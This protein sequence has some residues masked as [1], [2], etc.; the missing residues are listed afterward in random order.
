MQITWRSDVGRLWWWLMRKPVAISIG[1][2]DGVHAG[3]QALIKKA[4]QA[5]SGGGS[6]G[7]VV[8]LA[9]DPHPASVLRP[10]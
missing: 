7:Q 4:H 10:E 9:F 1:N 8:V 6:Q 2:F 5:V 3:H